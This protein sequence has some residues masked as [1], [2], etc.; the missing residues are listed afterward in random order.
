MIS[1]QGMVE[2]RLRIRILFYYITKQQKSQ[3]FLAKLSVFRLPPGVFF[4]SIDGRSQLCYHGIG[5][6][7]FSFKKAAM[8]VSMPPS[9]ICSALPGRDKARRGTIWRFTASRIRAVPLLISKNP[10]LLGV[11]FSFCKN[12]LDSHEILCYNGEL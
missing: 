7:I 4:T 3:Y 10:T 2:M 5:Y 9:Q 12:S 1:F 8:S 11:G 6:P